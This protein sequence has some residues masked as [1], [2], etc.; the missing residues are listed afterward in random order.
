MTGMPHP[1]SVALRIG[2]EILQGCGGNP[3]D[4]LQGAWRVT[5]IEGAPLPP[6]AEVTMTVS[7]E[8]MFG[9]SA[10]NRYTAGVTLTGEALSVLPGGMTMMACDEASMTIERQ[11]IDMLQK[12]TGFDSEDGHLILKAGDRPIA[13]AVPT[14]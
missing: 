8:Q 3:L 9:K 2:D 14:L 10:C 4:L 12:V 11:F 5:G 13:S 6:E 1:L 7:G